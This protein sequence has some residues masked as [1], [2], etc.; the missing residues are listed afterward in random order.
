MQLDDTNWRTDKILTL[1]EAARTA[2]ELKDAGKKLVTVNGSYD[3]LHVGHL[4]QLE[5]AKRQG[6]ALFVGVNSDVSVREAKGDDRPRNP[7]RARAAMLAALA[8]VD[9]VVVVDASY[10]D[11]PLVLLR[12]L[13]PDVHVNGPDYG[14]P[15]T[16]AEWPVMQE[17]GAAAHVFKKRNDIS[18]TSLLSS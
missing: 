12:A 1:D 7:E 8:A 17:V 10:A 4:D 13:K 3:I 2:A 5:E 11:M 16:W 9:Y 14:E 6:D 18:T 15:E